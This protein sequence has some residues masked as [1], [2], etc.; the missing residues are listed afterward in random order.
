MASQANLENTMKYCFLSKYEKKYGTLFLDD[1][2]NK[3]I[4]YELTYNSEL[5]LVDTR[6]S[7]KDITLYRDGKL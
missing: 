2:I 1:C 6:I 5:I 3:A 7:S 4:S